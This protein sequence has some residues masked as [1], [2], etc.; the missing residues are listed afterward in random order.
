MV[1]TLVTWIVISHKRFAVILFK[2]E[3]KLSIFYLISGILVARQ[4]QELR[5]RELDLR[6]KDQDFVKTLVNQ[7]CTN[8]QLYSNYTETNFKKHSYLMLH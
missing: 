7:L 3:S 5:L 6:G 8:A 1:L 4:D 2:K